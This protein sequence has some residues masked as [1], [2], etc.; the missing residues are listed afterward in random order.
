M[1][2]T[3]GG[4]TALVLAG[5]G[6]TGA[7]YEIGALRAIDDLLVGR[8]V[9]EFD[10]FVGTSAG[11]LVA[12]FLANGSSPEEM[13]KVLEGSNKDVRSIGRKDI[14]SLNYKNYLK[15]LL[16]L[17]FKL[18]DAWGE[19]IDHLN[20]VTLFDLGWNL[21]G[22]LPSGMY[23]DLALDH[24]IA[25]T[26]AKLGHHNLFDEVSASYILSRPISIQGKE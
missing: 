23:D 1:A 13:L 18:V 14:F 8:S 5:G 6:F 9:N 16:K 17:P 12:T 22:A 4:K 11:A 2:G 21:L 7:V 19:N 26:L 15:W 25:Q 24:Y 3:K 20:E 10:I